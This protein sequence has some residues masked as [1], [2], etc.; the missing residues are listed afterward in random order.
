[1]PVDRNHL[2]FESS[3]KEYF[4][5]E[6]EGIYFGKIKAIAS[7]QNLSDPKAIREIENLLKD[8]KSEIAEAQN[9]DDFG[10][11]DKLK[12]EEANAEIY[13]EECQRMGKLKTFGDEQKKISNR[14]NK[15]MG[16]ALDELKV[17]SEEAHAHFNE[18]FK[19]IYSSTKQYKPTQKPNW[20]LE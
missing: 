18:A 1:M 20:I 12:N 5:E 4:E 13:L 19:P 3:P 17:Y 7:R 14:V 11:V 8:L 6:S 2:P 10:L 9:N 16:R 15:A